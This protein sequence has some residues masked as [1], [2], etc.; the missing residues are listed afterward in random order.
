MHADYRRELRKELSIWLGPTAHV[1]LLA[2][3]S[4]IL[5]YL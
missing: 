3:S 5:V 1:E 2:D 4:G